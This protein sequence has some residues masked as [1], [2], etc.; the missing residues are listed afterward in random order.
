MKVEDA[1]VR[2]SGS[3]VLLAYLNAIRPVSG[4][5]I[6][7]A[8]CGCGMLLLAAAEMGV[9]QAVGVDLDP[10]AEN[11][12]PLDVLCQRYAILREDLE[13]LQGD[14]CDLEGY[15]GHFDA[16]VSMDTVEHVRCLAPYFAAIYRMLRPGGVALIECGALYYSNVGGH[17]DGYFD[18]AV[19]PWVH[20]Y[21]DYATLLDERGVDDWT[22]REIA[23]L[24]RLTLRRL[25][26]TLTEAGFEIR[27][28]TVGE[29]GR[30]RIEQHRCRID[31]S[32]VPA[33][34]DLFRQW[35]RI[36]A[37][38]PASARAWLSESGS[39]V[40]KASP[41][42]NALDCGGLFASRPGIALTPEGKAI[43]AAVDTAGALWACTCDPARQSSGQWQNIGGSFR[44]VPCVVPTSSPDALVCA[45]DRYGGFWIVHYDR[46]QGF[47]P[48]VSLGGIFAADPY[49]VPIP[50]GAIQ[51]SATDASSALWHGRFAPDY[52]FDGWKRA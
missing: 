31:F 14:L 38:K 52:G 42:G 16:A 25:V 15:D 7:D 12:R 28:Q 3:R 30:D 6:L 32:Q 41:E 45:G 9:A 18:A 46:R 13:L 34:E 4:A 17:V 27:H 37:L 29:L 10:G 8:G 44:G 50:G 51:I 49:A 21:R 36:A 40:V 39:V 47:G 43:M 48:P 26:D 1:E 2:L 24:N 20:L 11:P 19:L 35:V 5:R 22:R 23:N 33:E